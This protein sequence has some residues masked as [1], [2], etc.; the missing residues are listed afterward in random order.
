MKIIYVDIDGVVADFEKGRR[1]H[2]LSTITPYIV[3][4]TNYQEFM[5]I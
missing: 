2:P 1:N 4:L 3:G 5:S